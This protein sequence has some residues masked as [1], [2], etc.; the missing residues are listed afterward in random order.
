[1]IYIEKKWT[2]FIQSDLNPSEMCNSGPSLKFA[3]APKSA[4][5]EKKVFIP[6]GRSANVGWG[7]GDIRN[8]FHSI[9]HAPDLRK[10]DNFH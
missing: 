2:T 4:I 8:D 5:L 10:L 3:Y 9:L 6:P 1:M 7:D